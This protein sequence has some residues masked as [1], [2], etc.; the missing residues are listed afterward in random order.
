MSS[1]GHDL[2]AFGLGLSLLGPVILL[3][4]VK[5]LGGDVMGLSTRIALWVLACAALWIAVS[6][7]EPWK[8]QLG[9]KVPGWRT[10]LSAAS[11]TFVVMAA[12][13]LFQYLQHRLGSRSITQTSAFQEIAALPI[14]YRT[15]LIATAAIT[16]EILS[17][18]FAI[19][20]GGIAL[21]NIY[22]AASVSI[23]MFTLTHFRWG[24]SHLLSVFWAALV[25]TALFLVTE[26]LIACIAAHFALDAV[27]LIIAPLFISRRNSVADRRGSPL[28]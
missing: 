10:L 23:V 4:A 18:G 14:S 28:P 5:R 7:G 21:G 8:S 19:G 16:E 3:T 9:F 27:G 22:V 13:P 6:S 25:L 24:L 2:I 12:S 20:V 11:A 1:G 15:F 26:D 17:R